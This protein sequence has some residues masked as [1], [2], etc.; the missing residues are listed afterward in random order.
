MSFTIVALPLKIMLDFVIGLYYPHTQNLPTTFLLLPFITLIPR[1]FLLPFYYV[2]P[3][4]I[5]LNIPYQAPTAIYRS[6]SALKSKLEI[7]PWGRVHASITYQLASSLVITDNLRTENHMVGG[8]TLLRTQ[9]LKN[10]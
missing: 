2:F 10:H 5:R 6:A 1:T 4:D 7:P 9:N 8:Q 3:L